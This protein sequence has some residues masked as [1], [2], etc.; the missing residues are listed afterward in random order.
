M[1][2]SKRRLAV[3][4]QPIHIDNALMVDSVRSVVFQPGPGE[5]EFGDGE[6]IGVFGAVMTFKRLRKFAG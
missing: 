2:E 6:R 4:R 1:G 5:F 3:R